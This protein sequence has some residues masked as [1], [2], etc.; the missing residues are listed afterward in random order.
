MKTNK[1]CDAATY[2]FR[3][4]E[5]ILLDANIWLMLQP[6]SGRPDTTGATAVYSSAFARLMRANAEPVIE[7]LVLSEYLNR[8]LR[9]EYNGSWE[10]R[11]G[12]NGG[13]KAFRRSADFLP[14]GRSAVVDAR[15]ILSLASTRD[16]PL[17]LVDLPSILSETEAGGLDFNDGM[18]AETCRLRGWKLLTHDRDMTVGGIE[19][20]T[21]NGKLLRA[22][23]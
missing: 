6:P 11:Y 16:S 8:Y 21:A 9:L 12:R 17:H 4:G 20:L 23:P 5:K 14:L 19:V 3:A 22:C 7:S 1:A 2:P 18:L 13:F 10:G 15:R